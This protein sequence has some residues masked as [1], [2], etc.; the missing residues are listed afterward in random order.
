MKYGLN[1]FNEII[2]AEISK[3]TVTRNFEYWLV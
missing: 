2:Y 3:V 1:H